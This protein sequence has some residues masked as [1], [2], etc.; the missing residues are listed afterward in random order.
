MSSISASRFDCVLVTG[1]AGYIGSVLV[2]LLLRSGY[3]VRVLDCL[4]YGGTS[5]L[6]HATNERFE[7]I[8]GDIRS[9]ADLDGALKDIEAVVHLAAIVG[10]PACRR[11]PE[12]A[13]AINDDAGR[14]LCERA[15]AAGVRRFV[16]ASTCSNYGRMADP[17]QYVD[18]RSP[19]KPISLYA[20]L[21]VAFER[22][23]MAQKRDRFVPVCLRFATAYGLSP[24]PRFDLTVN[25][26]TC[27]LALGHRLEV[28]GEQ[29]WR[30]YCH[31]SDLACACLT[32]LE[33]DD[34]LVAHQAFN[35]G[36][37]GENYQK[38]TL[39]RLIAD[40]LGNDARSR[41][42]SVRCDEDPR[43]YRVSFDKIKKA[44]GFVPKQ[45]VVDGIR[46]IAAAIRTGMIKD[47]D[48]RLYRND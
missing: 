14:R 19:L 41:I 26:F 44:L 42:V 4:R 2:A 46:E 1:G 25:E 27:T 23:L 45:R 36:D 24:R 18:E 8:V 33:A 21:K 35:V 29:F 13:R 3:R 40:E 15:V 20:E 34:K 43:D 22:Y 16:F 6:A 17:S 38:I 28:Y 5:L 10:D 39:A 9:P 37:T 32:A 12:L 48:N 30:P 11:E 31:T 7:L 47:P